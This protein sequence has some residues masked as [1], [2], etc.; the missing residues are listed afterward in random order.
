MKFEDI[1]M[2]RRREHQKRRDLEEEVEELQEILQA[3]RNLNRA[4]ECAMRGPA[5]CRSCLSSFLPLKVQVLL[6]EIAMVEEEIICL[7]RKVKDLKLHLYQEREQKEWDLHEQ[8]EPK[9]MEFLCSPEDER[10]ALELVTETSS[11]SCRKPK[12]KEAVY[13]RSCNEP[14]QSWGLSDE[15]TSTESPN[16]LSEQLIKTLIIIFHKLHK[17][18]M[19]P[20]CKEDTVPKLNISCMSSRSVISRSSYNCKSTVSSS[21]T[22]Q[23]SDPYDVLLEGE[24]T[25]RDIGAYKKFIHFTKSSLDMTRIRL[26]GPAIRKLRQV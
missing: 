12:D 10:Y 4:L 21:N 15:E 6:A 14:N 13:S 25:A 5:V 22:L 7:E 16:K 8:R 19:Q 2:Q 9:Q 26:C 3:E 1:L 20:E 23:I 18:S 24:R 17:S 11:T